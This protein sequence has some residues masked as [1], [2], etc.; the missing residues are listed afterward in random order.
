MRFE[1]LDRVKRHVDMHDRSKGF[2]YGNVIKCFSREEYEIAGTVL[3]PYP[4]LYSVKWD[5][6]R[7][8][9][10]YLPFGITKI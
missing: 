4:E 10:S 2:K 1:L 9:K 6:G 8:G 3:G 5:N 7:I